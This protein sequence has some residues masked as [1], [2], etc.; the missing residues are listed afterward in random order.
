MANFKID[1]NPATTVGSLP[2]G[3][4]K[5]PDFLLT[6]TDLSDISLKDVAGKKVVL[7][8]FPSVDTPVCS[9]SVRRFNSEI[10]SCPGAVVLCISLDLPFAHSRFCE[11]EGLKDVIPVSELRN[12]AF[13]DGYGVRIAQGP[14]AG[15]L[16]RA[17]VV[18]D[19]TGTVIY[20]KLVEELKN[21][22]DYEAVLDLLK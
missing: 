12:R 10:S 3:G 9:A 1:G 8:I 22:P 2:G 17:V 14:L 11:T 21:E 20:S 19:E 15:L 18:I 6:K 7:N 4:E 5:A 16:A 13:G